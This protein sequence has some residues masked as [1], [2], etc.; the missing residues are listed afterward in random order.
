MTLW[1]VAWCLVPLGL[2]VMVRD[3]FTLSI[4]AAASV[5]ALYVASWDLVGGVSGQP[6]LGHALPMGAGAYLAAF[7]GGLGLVPFP[8][9][10][11][12]NP[13]PAAHSYSSWMSEGWSP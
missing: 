4:L 6:T 9:A 3:R 10:T 2:A 5:Q 13:S 12:S 8:A 11:T 7:L 1:R